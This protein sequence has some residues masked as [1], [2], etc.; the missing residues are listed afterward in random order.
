M[1]VGVPVLIVLFLGAVVVVFIALSGR[2]NY[3][4]TYTAAL[5]ASS[6]GN[7]KT[8]IDLFETAA[9]QQKEETKNFYAD[10]AKTAYYAGDIDLAKSMAQKAQKIDTLDPDR[11][12]L[13]E[14]NLTIENI[15][16]E[17]LPVQLD[18]SKQQPVEKDDVDGLIAG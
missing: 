17:S 4:T 2:G 14:V 11:A 9:S 15:L 3:A 6:K 16:D 12:S 1:R 5:D 8:A 18:T 13:G 7:Y 10:Y